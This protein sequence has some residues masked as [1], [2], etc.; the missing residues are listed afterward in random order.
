MPG[1]QNC[2]DIVV[3]PLGMSPRIGN[4]CYL[5]IVGSKVSFLLDC[6]L[7]TSAPDGERVPSFKL[8]CL[9]DMG[10]SLER[11]LDFII[12]SHA[13]FDHSGALPFLFSLFPNFNRPVY[14]TEATKFLL[15]QMYADYDRVFD[16]TNQSMSKLEKQARTA[17]VRSRIISLLRTYKNNTNFVADCQPSH[18]G[19]PVPETIINFSNA[20]HIIGAVITTVTVAGHAKIVYTGDYNTTARTTLPGATLPSCAIGAD[21]L[22]TETTYCNISRRPSFY[23]DSLQLA[24][25]AETLR[26]NGRV[27]LPTSAMGLCQDIIVKVWSFWERFRLNRNRLFLAT[28]MI[29]QM[30]DAQRILGNYSLDTTP[31]TSLP[32]YH[33]MREFDRRY[34][35]P[36]G[37]A[38]EE[39]VSKVMGG[40]SADGL[41]SAND[42]WC[43]ISAPNQTKTGVTLDCFMQIVQ[44][45]KALVAYPGHMPLMGYN[46]RIIRHAAKHILFDNMQT[47]VPIN[48]RATHLAF[49]AHVDFN[50]IIKTIDF[51]NPRAVFLIHNTAID[52]VV[53]FAELLQEYYR[54]SK[55]ICTGNDGSPIFAIP[56]RGYHNTSRA[57]LHQGMQNKNSVARLITSNIKPEEL[58]TK[59]G[60]Y[61]V[62]VRGSIRDAIQ[63]LRSH[64]LALIPV[65]GQDG[66]KVYKIGERMYLKELASSGEVLVQWVGEQ[67][68]YVHI[69]KQENGLCFK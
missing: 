42:S 56:L 60:L 23:R 53:R 1:V 25:V 17:E 14:T 65:A 62:R 59:A 43:V 6:G 49:N 69:T 32:I 46:W 47:A 31:F 30:T 29:K 54:K 19:K 12:I 68:A 26:Q 18:D 39:A 57:Y 55:I 27:L 10:Y 34:I 33:R 11:D 21:I 40:P 35:I 9:Q 58:D 4:S 28:G 22:I 37:T 41:A 38:T 45:P 5:V 67:D 44:D 48:C 66:D 20:G 8:K 52:N 15:P 13:H 7:R 63:S 51:L 3:I 16:N 50:G 61:R 36:T 2:C 64:G 24:D